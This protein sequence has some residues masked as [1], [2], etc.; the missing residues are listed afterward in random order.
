M[1]QTSLNDLPSQQVSHNPAI[2]KKVML[3]MGDLP[4]LTN[5][6]QAY[7]APGQIAAA[8]AHRDMC[9]VFF[10]Q[11]GEGTITINGAVYPLRAGSCIAVEPNEVHEVVNTGSEELVLTYFGIQ[12]EE[13]A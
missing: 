7:F 1:K 4:H 5:F 9:E 12:V 3:R 8:H 10:V 13:R 2:Q 11:A 6:S